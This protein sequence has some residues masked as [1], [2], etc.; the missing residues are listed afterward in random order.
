MPWK[1]SP[2]LSQENQNIRF[3]VLNVFEIMSVN[4]FSTPSALSLAAEVRW[5][6]W[7]RQMDRR[8]LICL[9]SCP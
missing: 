5:E 6:A 1:G 3:R 4:L 8:D 7:D 9:K 2:F